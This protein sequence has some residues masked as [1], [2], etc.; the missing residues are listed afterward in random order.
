MERFSLPPAFFVHLI[1]VFSKTYTQVYQ[2]RIGKVGLQVFGKLGWACNSLPRNPGPDVTVGAFLFQFFDSNPGS[3]NSLE[4]ICSHVLLK[5]YEVLSFR[6]DATSQ[7]KLMIVDIPKTAVSA[8]FPG[9]HVK[10]VI[11]HQLRLQNTMRRVL[12][13]IVDEDP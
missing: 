12:D 1:T 5:L 10:Q 13:R 6:Q 7:W 11:T 8:G 2:L 9:L 3:Q 4:S